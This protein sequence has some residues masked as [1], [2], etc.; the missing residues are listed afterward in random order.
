MCV[1]IDDLFVLAVLQKQSDFQA[2]DFD[3]SDYS[4]ARCQWQWRQRMTF[5]NEAIYLHYCCCCRYSYR[6][7]WT[8]LLAFQWLMDYTYFHV[9]LAEINLLHDLCSSGAHKN[10]THSHSFQQSNLKMKQNAIRNI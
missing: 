4:S 8:F 1:N 9:I 2:N 3:G 10:V 7:K 6:C 5:C